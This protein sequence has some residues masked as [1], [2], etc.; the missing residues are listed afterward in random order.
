MNKNTLHPNDLTPYLTAK[1]RVEAIA[2]LKY[3]TTIYALL[4]NAEIRQFLAGYGIQATDSR[5]V[6][7]QIETEHWEALAQYL[8]CKSTQAKILGPLEA[9]A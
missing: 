2:R 8:Q 4:N 9:A 3:G 1:A 6:R 7:S 5:I